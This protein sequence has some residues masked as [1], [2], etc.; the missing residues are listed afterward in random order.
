MK[1]LLP[2]FIILLGIFLIACGKNVAVSKEKDNINEPEIKSE[3][4]KSKF[5]VK[6]D[7]QEKE[8]S[9]TSNWSTHWEK[10]FQY[11]VDGKTVKEKS[12]H[13]EI[14][15]A[16]YELDSKD[17]KFSLNKQKIEKPE[18]I[19]ISFAFNGEKGTDSETA[20]KI[21]KYDVNIDE[22]D[23]SKAFGKID[24]I[25]IYHLV[26]GKEKETSL[27][28]KDLKG[29]LEILEVKDNTIKGKIDVTDGKQTIKGDFSAKGDNSIK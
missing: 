23:L 7:G 26:D 10:T 12:S 11:P 22:F 3:E 25:E 21:S 1:K 29:S 19:K 18:Q 8:F 16:N 13:T 2:L 27:K 5:T 14:Y 28:A 4:K 6:I 24:S 9:P 20:I 17:G 15:I